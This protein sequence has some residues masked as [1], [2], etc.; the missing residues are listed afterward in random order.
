VE[1]SG[2]AVAA[3]DVD[4]TGSFFLY[5]LSLAKEALRRTCRCF[6]AREIVLTLHRS[7][8]GA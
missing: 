4:E 1:A 2:A 7:D 5:L 6:E 3:A 8:A